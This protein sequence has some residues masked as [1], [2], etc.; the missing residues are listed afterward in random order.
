MY[1]FAR[2]LYFKTSV[3]DKTF[4]FQTKFAEKYIFPSSDTRQFEVLYVIED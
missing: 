2:H 1:I 3:E 4:T